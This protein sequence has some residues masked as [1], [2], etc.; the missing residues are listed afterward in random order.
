MSS[1]EFSFDKFSKNDFYSGVNARLVDMVNLKPG[2]RIVDLACGTG[3]VTRLIVDRVRGARES[4]IIAID[5]SSTALKQAAEK[6]QKM[7]PKY[8]IIKQGAK[9]ALLIHKN[10]FFFTRRSIFR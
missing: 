4:V 2:Q 7:G 1:D 3:G 6:I 8:I 9:G 5:H 10:K